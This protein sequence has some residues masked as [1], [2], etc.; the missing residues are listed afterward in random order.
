MTRLIITF[1]GQVQGVGFRWTTRSI[2]S[3][4]DVTGWVR[5]EPDGAVRC[6]VEGQ[7][8]EVDRFVSD[9]Q[10]EMSSNIHSTKIERTQP[11]GEFSGFE[12]R[13]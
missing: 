5:N 8:A 12:I 10:A 13:H 9:L 11:T 6:I 2:A 1:A 7:P 4:H 3:R